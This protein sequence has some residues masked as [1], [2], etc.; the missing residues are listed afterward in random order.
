M[1]KWP[2]YIR[3]T[4]GVLPDANAKITFDG[5]HVAQDLGKAFESGAW[6]G[7][8]AADQ[9]GRETDESKPQWRRNECN[10][11]WCQQRSFSARRQFSLK[12]SRA[13]TIKATASHRID[14][15]SFT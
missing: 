5:L 4:R 14:N 2:A 8:V 9:A 13:G 1:D 12:N 3:A 6:A 7:T 15:Q 11:K 10:V